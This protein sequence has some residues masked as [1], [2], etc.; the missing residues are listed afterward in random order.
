MDDCKHERIKSVNCVIYCDICGEK[1]PSD[2][3]PGKSRNAEQEAAKPA[4]KPAKR[5]TTRKGAK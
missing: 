2:Y 1:L 5:A 3:V 4:E